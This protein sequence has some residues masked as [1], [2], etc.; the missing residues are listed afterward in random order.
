[1]PN[2]LA[3]F[4]IMF[5]AVSAEISARPV[6]KLAGKG[7]MTWYSREDNESNIGNRDNTLVPFRSVAIPSGGRGKIKVGDTLFV[8][9]LRGLRI[10]NGKTH[11]GK[12]R[13]EDVCAGGGCK[14]LDLYVGSNAQRRH[15]QH[16]MGHHAHTDADV[17]EVTAYF[18]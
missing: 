2:K 14:F 4:C 10:G 15:Y 9:K 7:V 8:P 1:M 3:I 17:L 6:K 13:V 5:L 18:A 12:V 11:D 16:A